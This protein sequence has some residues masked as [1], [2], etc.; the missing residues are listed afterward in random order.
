MQATHSQATLPP[1]KVQ[2]QV[3]SGAAV[4]VAMSGGVDSTVAAAILQ[5]AGYQVH[6]FFM[7]LPLADLDKQRQKVT[8]VAAQLGIP[9]TCVDLR[10]QFTADII[11]HCASA[12]Q[13]GLTPNPC[14]H[15]NQHIKFGHLLQV[16]QKRG[17]EWMATGHYAQVVQ[18]GSSAHLLRGKDPAKDQSYFLCRLENHQRR[19][20]VLPLGEYSKEQVYQKA[21]DLGLAFKRQESQD[22]CFFQKDLGGFLASQGVQPL[23][24]DIVTTDGRCMGMHNGIWHYTIGQRRG[25]GLPDTT[26]WYVVRLDAE[27]NRVVIG[28]QEQLVRT[29]LLMHSVQWNISPRREWQGEVQIRS[30]HRAA[31]AKLHEVGQQRCLITFKKP[32]RAIT[33][34]QYGVLYNGNHLVG[35]GIIDTL[36]EI[37][38]YNESGCGNLRL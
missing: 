5:E 29:K 11:D 10:K 13:K 24:G 36:Q 35:S 14:V 9:L 16:I 4:G 20:L 26:P 28:K 22:V 31:A 38:V 8:R 15:C 34:G 12:Y 2:N 7:V 27:N 30:R 18:R 1:M 19:N 33:P 21:S 37:E 23:R 25:L 3:V 17:V 32:Q 6:G